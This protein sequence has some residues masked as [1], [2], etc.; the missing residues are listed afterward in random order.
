MLD[1]NGNAYWVMNQDDKTAPE[2]S[3][4]RATNIR[5]T[6]Y[7]IFAYRLNRT[8]EL[9]LRMKSWA[10]LGL[11]VPAWAAN[12]HYDMRPA[13]RPAR[14]R[15]M[16]LMMQSLLAE[17]FKL[18]MHKETRQAPVFAMALEKPGAMAKQ[19]RAHPA[20]DTCA[21]TVF[22]DAAGVG[23]DTEKN[24]APKSAGVPTA[25]RRCR[26]PAD[27]CAPAA[28]H[29]GAAQDWRAQRDADDGG[30][31]IPAQTGLATFPKPVI[32]RAGLSGTFD[33]S[34]E[35]TQAVA[36]DMAV[37]PNEQGEEPGRRLRRR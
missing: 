27:D 5:L 21:T 14:P 12:T 24:G 19:L 23:A 3:L 20:S 2:G 8:E 4:F 17:R 15:Q 9:A 10:G 11:D 22:P 16:R 33:F 31:V 28:Q 36:S 13:R 6:R 34:L 26:F 7:I 35:W 1:S 29:A 30:G 32:N 37:G 25:A 18:A